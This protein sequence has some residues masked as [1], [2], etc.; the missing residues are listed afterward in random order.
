MFLNNIKNFIKKNIWY[1]NNPKDSKRIQAKILGIKLT[2]PKKLASKQFIAK[3]N[4]PY[5]A[6][7]NTDIPKVM[8]RNQALEILLNSQKSLARFGDGEFNLIFGN[9]LPFQ[10]YSK[11]LAD[12]L[13]YILQTDDESVMTGIPNNFGNLDHYRDDAVDFWRKYHYRNR[14]NIYTLLNFNKQYYDA[15]ISR[16]YISANDRSY[17]GEYFKKFKQLWENKDIVFVEGKAS[18]LGYQNDLFSNAKSIKRIICPP[19]N[20]WTKYPEIL[21]ACNTLPKNTLFILALG[22]TAT[23]LAYDLCKSEYRALDLGHI[24]IEYEWF[25]MKA[26]KKVPIKNKYVNEAKKGRIITELQDANYLKEIYK[27]FAH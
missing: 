13:K 8:E 12:R 23:V 17:C 2:L 7:T 25:L 10:N 9:N 20:A 27:N 4:Y 22:P 26:D 6:G 11:E 14:Q 18:R 19:Q 3:Q 16:P 1:I 21:A 15:E 5:E 24:D